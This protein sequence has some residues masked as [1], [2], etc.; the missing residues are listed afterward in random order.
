M[1]SEWDVY[2]LG[3]QPE[4]WTAPSVSVGRRNGKAYPA[5][6]Q[7]T[8]LK[9]YK[10]AVREELERLGPRKIDGPVQL[11]LYFWRA[12][13]VYVSESPQKGDID[14]LGATHN[15]ASRKHRKHEADL[16]NMQKLLED[17]LQGLLF[18]ND[19]DVK[20]VEVTVVEQEKDTE[21]CVVIQIAQWTGLD[22]EDEIIERVRS[23]TARQVVDVPEP[24]DVE[25]LF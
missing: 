11:R 20:H 4:P 23:V 9:A 6:Y 12:L 13:P 8:A 25:A 19:R 14:V 10:E 18:D 1:V 24:F 16:T 7:S 5:V 17:S 15:S 22:L 3:V 2:V 21:P